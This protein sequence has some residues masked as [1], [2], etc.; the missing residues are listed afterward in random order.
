VIDTMAEKGKYSLLTD[1]VMRIRSD[2]TYGPRLSDCWLPSSTWVEALRK[3]NPIDESIEIDVRKFNT[4][5]SKSPLFGE[6]MHQFDGSNTTGV[7][8]ITFQNKIFNF[9]TQESR[10]A[11]YPLLLNSVWKDNLMEAAADVLV[12][13]STRARPD[14][15]LAVVNMTG[16]NKYDTQGGTAY[17]DEQSVRHLHWFS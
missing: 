15:R 16:T 10:Q 8:R 1:A 9:F 7:F 11:S 6:V 13:P 12:I 14:L 2:I 5:M 17:E 3:M 4:A